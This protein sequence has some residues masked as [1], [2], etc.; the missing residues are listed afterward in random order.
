MAW[1]RAPRVTLT[2]EQQDWRVWCSP[3]TRGFPGPSPHPWG[4]TG[5]GPGE[6][7]CSGKT[8]NAGL[9]AWTDS[10]CPGWRMDVIAPLVFFNPVLATHFFAS[11]SGRSP[12]ACQDSGV[13][14]QESQGQGPLVPP[15]QTTPQKDRTS[16]REKKI[17]SVMQLVT[18]WA[19]IGHLCVAD[20]PSPCFSPGVVEED[21][22]P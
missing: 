4:P 1:N 20:S 3:S 12:D 5:R 17:L 11:E 21:L 22:C 16:K 2:E 19:H 10:R 9:E 15:S 13:L 8:A 6:G 14:E 7:L 18:I